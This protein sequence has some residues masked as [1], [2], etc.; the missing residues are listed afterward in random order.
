[1]P[2]WSIGSEEKRVKANS[3]VGITE[4]GKR[5]AS[6]FSSRGDSFTILS[7]LEDK[8]PQTVSQVASEAQLP[9]GEVMQ[10]LKIMQKQGYVRFTGEQ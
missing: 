7:V 5:E 8:S 1:M 2:W 9:E 10:R 4:S 6:R 3:T